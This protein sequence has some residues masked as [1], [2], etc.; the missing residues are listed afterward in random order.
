VHGYT[1]AF[2]FAAV[3]FAVGLVI[4]IVVLPRRVQPPRPSV[5]PVVEGA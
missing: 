3:L 5:E 2:T 4:A 1:S